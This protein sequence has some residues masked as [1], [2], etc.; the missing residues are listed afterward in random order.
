MARDVDDVLADLR[1]AEEKI[2][3]LER[4][5]AADAAALESQG[6]EMASIREQLGL[7]KNAA[8]STNQA[9]RGE[10]EM[11]LAQVIEANERLTVTVQDLW[12][13]IRE[14]EAESRVHPKV[15]TQPNAG[16]YIPFTP[17]INQ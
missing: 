2:V 16:G 6:K 17:Q 4:K 9:L 14:M 11:S 12:K 8:L 10:Y 1:D 3:L 7:T 15:A 5:A 13:T